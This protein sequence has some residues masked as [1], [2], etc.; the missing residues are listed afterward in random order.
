MRDA[1]SPTSET[2]Q[3]A[4]AVEQRRDL[5]AYGTQLVMDGR[6]A[7][8]AMLGSVANAT[9]YVRG[10]LSRLE[11]GEGA[12]VLTHVVESGAAAGLS[13]AA[14]SGE[15]GVMVHTFTAIG[16]LTVRLVTSRSVRVDEERQAVV[17]AFGVGRHQTHVT[18]R[19]RT[20]APGAEMLTRQLRG[21]RDYAQVRLAEPLLP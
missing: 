14:R 7:D 6:A 1:P 2:Q 19:F 17:E 21:E 10:V 3:S 4:D 16:R 15:T 20:M 8:T 12:E 9:E 11:P 5:L 13:A 18:A